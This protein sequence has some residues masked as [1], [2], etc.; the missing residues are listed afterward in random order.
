MKWYYWLTI[1]LALAIL[2]CLGSCLWISLAADKSDL[3]LSVQQEGLDRTEQG[4]SLFGLLIGYSIGTWIRIMLLISFFF[5]MLVL[6]VTGL[7]RK[8]SPSAKTHRSKT[9]EP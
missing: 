9:R 2:A 3:V 5:G 7:T 8:V 1:Y 6:V 4:A